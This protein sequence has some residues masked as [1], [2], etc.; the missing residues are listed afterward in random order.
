M[1]TDIRAL[2]DS[3]INIILKITRNKYDQHSNKVD[4]E[5]K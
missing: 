4:Y 3:I 1:F 2:Y 5:K